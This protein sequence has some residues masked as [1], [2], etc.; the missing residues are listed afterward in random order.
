MRWYRRNLAIRI[1]D[2]KLAIRFNQ[3][4]NGQSGYNVTLFKKQTS[5]FYE[6]KLHLEGNFMKGQVKNLGTN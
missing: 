3:P 4:Y 6:A 5:S 2:H 1:N